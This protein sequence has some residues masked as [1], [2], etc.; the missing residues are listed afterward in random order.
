MTSSVPM[1]PAPVRNERPARP[2]HLGFDRL[3]PDIRARLSAA[4]KLPAAQQPRWPDEG[5]LRLATATLAQARPVVDPAEIDVL[6]ARLADVA[7][8]RAFLLQGGDCAETFEGNTD[9]HVRRNV[10][11]VL[12]MGVLLARH[13]GLPIVHIGR[14]A[15]QYAKPRSADTDV[16]GLPTYRGDA[17]NSLAPEVAERVPDPARMVRAHANAGATMEVVHSVVGVTSACDAVSGDP[18]P[19]PAFYSGHEALLL[20]YESA[21]VRADA[22]GRAYATSAHF[23]WIGERTRQLDGAHIAFAELMANPIG[24][25]IGP[26][27][28]PQAAVEYVERLD[29]RYQPGRV[30]L[31]PRMGNEK[32]REILPAIVEKVAAS[33]HEVVWQCDPMHGNTHQSP[34]GY[35][36][37]HFDRIVNEV[38]GFFEIHR[39]LGTYPGGIHL[40]LTGDDVTECLGG[41]QEVS[42]TDLPIRYETACDPRLNARQSMELAFLVAEMMGNRPSG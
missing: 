37:R 11:L 40:E 3:E 20:D 29:P 33:G 13:A 12:R 2:G 14:I 24:L 10:H 8:G 22:R 16:A 5:A 1:P 35:K 6:S 19:A 30:T 31:V 39:G 27:T 26:S 25:K 15:G 7:R 41:A 34:T 18:R 38:R 28:T 4:L 9:A 23:L 36:T 17:V 42:D 21:L 32:I